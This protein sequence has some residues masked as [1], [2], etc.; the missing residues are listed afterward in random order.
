VQEKI[1][2]GERRVRKIQIGIFKDQS[3]EATDA[4]SHEVPHGMRLGKLVR[5]MEK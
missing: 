1:S 4:T 3:I 2:A 5:S